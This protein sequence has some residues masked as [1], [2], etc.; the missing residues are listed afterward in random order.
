MEM[1]QALESLEF[2]AGTVRQAD[3]ALD[4][5]GAIRAVELAAEQA[6]RAVVS[7]ARMTEFS[8]S[9]IGDA[10][11]VSKQA[12]HQRYAKKAATP[13]EVC[14]RYAA[15]FLDRDEVVKQLSEWAY[16]PGHV[17]DADDF[18]APQDGTFEDVEAASLAGLI[19][20]EIYEAVLR[21]VVARGGANA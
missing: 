14:E 20:R 21:A 5:L 17:A 9:E 16:K 19:D 13:Y 6:R 10:L 11:G 15:G 7:H 4:M 8:W 12:A 18:R 3:D 1:K 2:V